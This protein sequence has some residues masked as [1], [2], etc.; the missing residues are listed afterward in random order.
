MHDKMIE[1][2]SKATIDCYNSF[3]L[4]IENV[5]YV[6]KLYR[7]SYINRS[8][9]SWLLKQSI[10]WAKLLWL[11]VTRYSHQVTTYLMSTVECRCSD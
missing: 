10:F 9:G 1:P 11:S 6:N 2:F 3:V 5:R 8:I 7:L 4:T